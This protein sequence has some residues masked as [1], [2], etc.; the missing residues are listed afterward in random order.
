MPIK[1]RLKSVT[2]PPMRRKVKSKTPAE[3]ARA[4]KAKLKRKRDR[5][6]I[7]K[8]A[9]LRRSRQTP[10]EKEFNRKRAAFLRKHRKTTGIKT[11]KKGT[12]LG[13]IKSA[14]K[15]VLRIGG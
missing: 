11:K 12:V 14:I 9:K 5:V 2:A 7:A 3:K 1:R 15:S 4:A 13:K 6:K 10:A 8:A